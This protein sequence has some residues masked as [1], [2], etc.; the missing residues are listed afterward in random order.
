MILEPECLGC[1][2]NQIYKAFILLRPSISKEII[3]D[4]Q[5]SMMEYLTQDGILSKP[6]PL[7]GKKVYD[8]IAEVLGDPDPYKDLK[9]QYNRLA[10]EFYDEAKEIIASAE[11]PLFEAIAVSTIGNTID[12]GSHHDMDLIKDLKNFKPENFK[13]NDITFLRKSM[14]KAN[15]NKG[16]ILIL[17][18]NAGEIVFDKILIETLNYLYVN[19]RIIYSV[20]AGPIINDATMEDA[21]F[22]GLTEIVKVIKAPATPG[23]ELSIANDEF[24]EYFSED[25]VLISKGQGNF[26][27]IY[28]M[29]IP[30]KDVYYLLKAKCSLMERIFDV[31]IGD[32]IFKKKT[33]DF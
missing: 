8:L 10:L 9:D 12:F 30:H 22:I 18:D 20:R 28:G 5:K 16:Q 17:G 3:I 11:D 13:I 19:V 2:I 25:G 24:K 27:S 4:C 15:K 29:E 7:I 33:Q 6:G 32:L 26:E 23:I 1:L 31:K 14:E 21:K